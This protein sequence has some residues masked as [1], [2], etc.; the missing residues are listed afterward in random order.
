MEK[1]V[2]VEDSELNGR[3]RRRSRSLEEIDR[4]GDGDGDEVGVGSGRWADGDGSREED[5][6]W[7]RSR[8][9]SRTPK[10]GCAHA[11]DEGSCEV[12]YSGAA[13][14]TG[15]EAEYF[16]YL[17][18][19]LVRACSGGGP[20]K[21]GSGEQIPR[22]ERPTDAQRTPPPLVEKPKDKTTGSKAARES[23]PR[24]EAE[25]DRAAH[26][27]HAYRASVAAG[28]L[29]PRELRSLECRVMRAG[30]AR[31]SAESKAKCGGVCAR[32]CDPEAK[33]LVVLHDAVNDTDDDAWGEKRG[34]G[35]PHSGT[36]RCEQR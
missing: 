12:L 18:P 29:P 16:W 1:S 21:A 34:R 28:R 23:A 24:G 35:S 5:R 20:G 17:A 31:G 22:R 32:R 15:A 4:T 2:E 7:V 10:Q 19:R 36:A 13:A 3:G 11:D 6:Q 33:S 8:G 26:A 27:V 25:A 9:W 14:N 30:A